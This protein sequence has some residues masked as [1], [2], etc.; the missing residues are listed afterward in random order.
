MLQIFHIFEEQK[1]IVML[2]WIRRIFRNYF[3][4]QFED[5]DITKKE[6]IDKIMLKSYKRWF[7]K[8]L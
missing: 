4:S 1:V 5:V 2:N 6:G 7:K 8:Y 3:T